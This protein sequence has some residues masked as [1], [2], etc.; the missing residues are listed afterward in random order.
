MPY[1]PGTAAAGVASAQFAG[2]FVLP[3]S[4]FREVPMGNVM[5]SRPN[6]WRL[7][8]ANGAMLFV[9]FIFLAASPAPVT[10]PTS[11]W[12]VMLLL[13]AGAATLAANIL[14]TE[15]EGSTDGR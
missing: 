14:I 10:F 7:A 5:P 13:V 15:V 12:E 9:V 6:L 2:S 3:I 11:H 4:S 1:S 8:V